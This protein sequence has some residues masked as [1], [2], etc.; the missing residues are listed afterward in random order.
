MHHLQI[1]GIYAVT[2]KQFRVN[3]YFGCREHFLDW[4]FAA[5]KPLHRFVPLDFEPEQ[6]FEPAAGEPDVPV[7]EKQL[8]FA[9]ELLPERGK[10]V[11]QKEPPLTEPV[12]QQAVHRLLCE[13]AVQV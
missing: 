1:Y 13:K 2:L 12:E 7:P 6:L 8:V 5:R 9:Q 4:N 11:R 10:P 3:E